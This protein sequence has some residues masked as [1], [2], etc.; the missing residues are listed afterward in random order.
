MLVKRADVHLFGILRIPFDIDFDAL[1]D[2]GHN[3]ERSLL[4]YMLV[5]ICSYLGPQKVPR[6]DFESIRLLDPKQKVQTKKNAL[7]NW[8]PARKGSGGRPP[9]EKHLG[10]LKILPSTV[11]PKTLASVGGTHKISSLT[12]MALMKDQK[13][14][15]EK[16]WGPS[17]ANFIN[18]K[19]NVR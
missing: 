13:S 14:A 17:S 7:G 8:V 10:V 15:L 1:F 2:H 19:I 4:R 5:R 6:H 18:N 16:V 11:P 9:R 12:H 3:P